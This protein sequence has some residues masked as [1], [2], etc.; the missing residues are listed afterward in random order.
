MSYFGTAWAD[1]FVAVDD[2]APGRRVLWRPGA[3][4]RGRVGGVAMRAKLGG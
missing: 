3:A 2:A 4:E 1:D